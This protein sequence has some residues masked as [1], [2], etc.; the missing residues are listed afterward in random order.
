MPKYSVRWEIDVEADTPEAAARQ[1]L[2]IHRDPHSIATVFDVVELVALRG[3]IQ[4]PM[5]RIDLGSKEGCEIFR[6]R[7]NKRPAQNIDLGGEDA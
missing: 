7:R 5:Q 4:K 2:T 3:L 1:A 6:V